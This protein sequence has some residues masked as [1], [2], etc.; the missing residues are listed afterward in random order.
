MRPW[1]HMAHP[2]HTADYYDAPLND[3]GK[4]FALKYR[5]YNGKENRNSGHQHAIWRQHVAIKS[6]LSKKHS[7]HIRRQVLYRQSV[8][9]AY[10]NDWWQDKNRGAR[11]NQRAPDT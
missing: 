6:A 2:R 7:N 4:A 3:G 5:G 10:E 8:T 1:L 11:C 9:V